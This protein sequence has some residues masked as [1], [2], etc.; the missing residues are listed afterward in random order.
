MV[1][2]HGKRICFINDARW[3]WK[4]SDTKLSVDYLY[5]TSGYRGT[6]AELE[7]LFDINEVVIDAS[8]SA[9][10]PN[11]L[12]TECNERHIPIHHLIDEGILCIPI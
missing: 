7:E 11:R 5:I 10:Y 9:F 1:D 8:L 3:R 12:D 6:L 4:K 2:Y